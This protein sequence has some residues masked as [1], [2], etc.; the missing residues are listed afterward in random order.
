M[1]AGCLVLATLSTDP[2]AH[3]VIRPL[4]WTLTAWAE[5]GQFPE[6]TTALQTAIAA[7]QHT[8][9]PAWPPV[10]DGIVQ[11]L[12]AAQRQDWIELGRADAGGGHSTR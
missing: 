9:I 4:A 1:A 6:A 12:V 3:P 11:L 8:L 7:A 10:L 5:T 2:A